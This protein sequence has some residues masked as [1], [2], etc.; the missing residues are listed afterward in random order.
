MKTGQVWRSA[1]FTSSRRSVI[2]FILCSAWA[3]IFA[4]LA[5][6]VPIVPLELADFS[7]QDAVVRHGVKTA[8]PED[9]VFLAVDEASLDLDQLDPEEIE[10]SSSLTLMSR[11]FPWSRA[12]YA[13]MIEKVLGAGAKVVVLDVS[14]PKEGPGDEVL[15]DVLDRHRERVVIGSVFENASA[16]DGSLSNLYRE[17][18][19][20][21]LPPGAVRDGVVGYVNFWPEPDRVVRGAHYRI[22]D[23]ELLGRPEAGWEDRRSLASLALEKAGEAGRVPRFG[24]MR[25]C[26]PESFR[27]VPLWMIFVPDLWDAN[28]QNGEIFRDKIVLLGPLASRFRDHF[29]TPVGTLPG[30]E[31][32]LHAMAAAREQAFYRRAS[33]VAVMATCLAMG[34]AAFGVSMVLRKPL[35]ALG[36]LGVLV[37]GYGLATLLIFNLL[38]I[39]PGLLY[40]VGT[41]VFAGLTAFAYD[42]SLERREKARVRRSLERYVSR[43]VVRE[44][45][46]SGS[47][48]LAELGGTRKDVA[49]LFSDLR[50]FTKLSE[51]ADPAVLVSHLNEYL[52]SMV[53]I[54]FRN[55]GTLD[56][57]I[58][59]AVMAVWGT[60]QSAGAGGDARRAVQTALDM[61]AAVARLRKEWLRRDAPDLRLGIGLHYG[62]AIFGNIGSDLKMEPT[63]IGDTVNL[64]SR[65]ESLTKHYGLQLLLS[66]SVADAAAGGFPFRTVDTVRVVGREAPVAIYTVPLDGE[67]LVMHPDW[68]DAHERAWA[69]Y[70]GRRFEEAAGLFAEVAV[71]SVGD[72]LIADMLQRSREF[73]AN[74]PGPEWEPV[75]VMG[76]K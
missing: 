46:D 55:N 22:N 57:F 10:A 43:D 38:D 8:T 5:G 31:I 2:L 25:F 65:L 63:V 69:C 6:P 73:D 68:L 27:T 39:L 54:V 72:A 45:L 33:S 61:L 35:I 53:E 47:S 4:L 3:V 14:F 42:F 67:N 44:L 66:G 60:I 36:V 15:R 21:V 51:R 48:V 26:E 75:T 18:S 62:P 70:R 9:F 29:R 71:A 37:L 76:S 52:G 28:L 40:P 49:V 13:E 1:L 19:P 59:D 7:L 12:V 11:E 16:S 32:H 30:P 17:P 34:L 50:G 58:G 24:L 56:K 74:P 41:L 20:S 23:G 64:A